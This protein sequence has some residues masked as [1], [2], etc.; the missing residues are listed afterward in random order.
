MSIGW[1]QAGQSLLRLRNPLLCSQLICLSTSGPI[2]ADRASTLSIVEQKLETRN[3]RE[4]QPNHSLHFVDP[5]TGV[6]RQN[7][8]S[9]WSRVKRRF[10]RMK[11][12]HQSMM[13][14]YLDEFMWRERG[15]PQL[16]LPVCA[17]I[18]L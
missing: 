10:K 4:M 11:G 2:T 5:A 17:E 14:A 16:H 12:V 1:L 9:Y 13:P 15:V 7:I 3:A 18:S 8:E 6:H